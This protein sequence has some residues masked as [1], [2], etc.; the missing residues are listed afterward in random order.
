M[1]RLV[2]SVRGSSRISVLLL[3]VVVT[4]VFT[5]LAAAFTPSASAGNHGKRGHP[6]LASTKRAPRVQRQVDKQ[7]F[8]ATAVARL[9]M[10]S[11][12]LA[13]DNGD[14]APMSVTAVVTSGAKAMRSA[15]PGSNE[16]SFDGVTV[17]LITMVGNFKGY[18]FR[19][20]PGAATPTGTVLSIIVNERTFRIMAMSL[21]PKQ[22]AIKP[23]S[24]GRSI[25][26]HWK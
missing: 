17:Y 11:R 22:S 3:A 15:T 5:L 16:R 8:S 7:V 6:E 10:I 2:Q 25:V 13:A 26:L 1:Y 18:G 4:I 19:T 23:T 20:P 24:L 9:R 12:T 14:R 21:N